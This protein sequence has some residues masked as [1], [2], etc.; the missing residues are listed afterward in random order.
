MFAHGRFA[1]TPGDLQTA[2]IKPKT[3]KIG[4]D[5]LIDLNTLSGVT[6]RYDELGQLIYFTAPDAVRIPKRID[7]GSSSKPIDFSSV[8][9]NL[10]F[11]LNYTLYGAASWDFRR[12][13]AEHPPGLPAV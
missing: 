1:A 10:G 3:G 4:A 8:R 11:V 9:S 13:A 5:G 12:H 2:G 6:W 7:V